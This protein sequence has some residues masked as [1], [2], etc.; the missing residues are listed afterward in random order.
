MAQTL[1]FIRASINEIPQ[2]RDQGSFGKARHLFLLRL[3]RSL[4]QVIQNPRKITFSLQGKDARLVP[5][6]FDCCELM[7][8]AL[9]LQMRAPGHDHNRLLQAQG[10]D[11]GS[12]PGMPDDYIRAFHLLV[13]GIG[14]DLALPLEMLRCV[15]FRTKLSDLSKDFGAFAIFCTPLV[16]CAGQAV[17]RQL[18]ANGKKNHNTAP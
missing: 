1:G 17:K 15:V 4:D 10:G 7:I 9:L 14:A 2:L 18:R 12:H 6:V 3:P 8:I 11:D 13:E 16:K 5:K